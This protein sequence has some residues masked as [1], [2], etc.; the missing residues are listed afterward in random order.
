MVSIIYVLLSTPNALSFTD[1]L[2]KKFNIRTTYD[3]CEGLPTLYGL[4]IHGFILC[5]ITFFI[6]SWKDNETTIPPPI[7][8]TTIGPT[9][10]GTI[11]SD[12]K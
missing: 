2:T 3:N 11:E 1:N 6:L 8:P 7:G 12:E 9:T 5:I 10:I 4:V